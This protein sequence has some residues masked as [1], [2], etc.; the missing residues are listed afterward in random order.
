MHSS[1]AEG[2]YLPRMTSPLLASAICWLIL[3]L[4]YKESVCLLF[5]F[6]LKS[7]TL[8]LYP[9]MNLG[10][11]G[12]ENSSA[13]VTL[14][15]VPEPPFWSEWPNNAIFLFYLWAFKS[16]L[17][18][19]VWLT[20]SLCS[21][22]ISRHKDQQ[23]VVFS[24][25]PPVRGQ[26]PGWKAVEKELRGWRAWEVLGMGPCLWPWSLAVYCWCIKHLLS[27]RLFCLERRPFLRNG[28]ESLRKSEKAEKVLG[29]YTVKD[30]QRV[31]KI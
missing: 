6:N 1:R 13:A 15:G 29:S 14:Q 11:E 16:L 30:V 2:H 21:P 22:L 8:G 28:L 9:Q 24:Q 31:R 23:G 3:V 27:N 7:K 18:T 5:V 4:P 19:I 25:I 26:S 10:V 12:W 20:V 17:Q